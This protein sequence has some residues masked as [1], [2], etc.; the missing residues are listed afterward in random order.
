MVGHG[1]E[2]RD[3]R[4]FGGRPRPSSTETREA[5][6]SAPPGDEVEAAG[7]SAEERAAQAA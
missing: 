1:P 7:L 5:E 4:H 3:V 2:P 6:V